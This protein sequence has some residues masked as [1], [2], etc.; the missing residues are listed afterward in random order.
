MFA[1]SKVKI[2]RS[3][4]SEMSER[5]DCAAIACSIINLGQNLN[6][7]TVAEGV[8]T[9]PQLTMLRVAGCSEAQGY[10][11]SRPLPVYDLRFVPKLEIAS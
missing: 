9:E 11:F 1:F 4:V 3:F 8:E 7:T 5:S 6:M 10:L 2:D